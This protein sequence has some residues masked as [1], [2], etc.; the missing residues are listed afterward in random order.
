MSNDPETNIV[1]FSS[2]EGDPV[3]SKKQAKE[4]TAQ[5]LQLEPE[6]VRVRQ[7][8]HGCWI[9]AHVPGR[10]FPFTFRGPT[11]F[12][13]LEKVHAHLVEAV[14]S[15]EESKEKSNGDN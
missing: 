15:D 6:G 3:V 8:D 14:V 4:I 12:A 10:V 9:F 7:N 5:L 13:A 11:W 2:V 1:P